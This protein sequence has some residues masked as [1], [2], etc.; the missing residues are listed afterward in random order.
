MCVCVCGFVYLCGCVCACIGWLHPMCDKPILY[1]ICIYAFL[2][3][4]Q[5]DHHGCFS[6][7]PCRQ[8]GYVPKRKPHM[9]AAIKA[10]EGAQKKTSST[11]R[12]PS[13]MQHGQYI[14]CSCIY[15]CSSSAETPTGWSRLTTSFSPTCPRGSNS[16][17]R[18]LKCV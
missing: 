9:H 15:I 5:G 6:K 4:I 1:V 17:P 7:S 3:T 8:P 13:C 2:S 10:Y 14:S 11:K 12:L 18:H 16:T